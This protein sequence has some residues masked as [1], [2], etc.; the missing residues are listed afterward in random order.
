MHDL[1]RRGRFFRRSSTLL[2]VVAMAFAAIVV[3]NATGTRQPAAA[4]G[5]HRGHDAPQ[6]LPVGYDGYLVF[7]ANG[8]WNVFEPHPT[9]PG[10][11]VQPLICDGQYFHEQIMKRTADEIAAKRQ[12]AIEHYKE[13]FGIDVNDPA[14]EGRVELLSFMVDPRWNYRVYSWGGRPVPPEGYQVRDGGF[15]LRITDPDGYTLG[16]EREGVHVP[17][18]ARAL[19]GDYNI[20]VERPSR[21]PGTTS[22]AADHRP[23]EEVVISYRA[24]TFMTPNQ[25]GDIAFSCQLSDDGFASGETTG[26]A[27]GFAN[28]T[29][30]PD[31]FIDINVRNVLTFGQA[32]LRR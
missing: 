30:G 15:L 28:Q 21:R 12:E 13:K 4:S 16:G 17:A 19:V 1:S 22:G 14:N 25:F 8:S 32:D 20:L 31:G 23:R 10:C 18:N 26:F 2:A 5:E 29:I 6:A 3:P 9:V 24:D 7:A 11:G 27:Q